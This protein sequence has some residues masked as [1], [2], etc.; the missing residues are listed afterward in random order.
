MTSGSL[1]MIGLSL[2]LVI[3][4]L[5][6]FAHAQY[7]SP[8]SPVTL[9]WSTTFNFP[10][11]YNTPDNDGIYPPAGQTLAEAEAANS[12]YN[13]NGSN[14]YTQVSPDADYPGGLG[15]NGLRFWDGDSNNAHSA[16]PEVFFSAPQREAVAPV[17]YAV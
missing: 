10:D 2:V 13:L 17:V 5:P 3:A 15:G 6:L 1:K 4:V 14:E 11:I 12:L 7:Q 9:P 8:Q 16:F